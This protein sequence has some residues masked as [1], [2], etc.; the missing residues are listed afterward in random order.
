MSRLNSSLEK[1]LIGHWTMSAKDISAGAISD[2][3]P[4]NN[5]GTINGATQTSGLF[6][7]G[8]NFSSA[9]DHVNIPSQN[10]PSGSEPRTFAIW[11]NVEQIGDRQMV[12]GTGSGQ[13]TGNAFEIEVDSPY[14]SSVKDTSPN[15]IGVHTWGSSAYAS[16]KPLNYNSWEHI[17]ATL[18]GSNNFGIQIY[19]NGE[20][21]PMGVYQ[22]STLSTETEHLSIGSSLAHGANDINTLTGSVQDARIYNRVL[23]DKEISTLYNMRS[24]PQRNVKTNVIYNN[25]QQLY[26]S[27]GHPETTSALDEFFNQS[28]PNV[29]NI[30]STKHKRAS[31]N[32]G[33]NEQE[34]SEFGTVNP[35]PKYFTQKD[36]Y[37]WKIE[38]K[39]T[40]PETG[41]YTFGI[42]GDDAM[43]VLING[44]PVTTFYG[45]H[46]F[47][48]TV[49]NNTGVT[50]LN[51]GERYTI[52]FRYEEGGGGNGATFSYKKPSDSKYVL[53]PVQQ[54]F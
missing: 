26:N 33:G 54:V 45:G 21:Q 49:N 29:T 31:V 11:V 25:T 36:G 6:D 39:W 15:G 19:H 9:S 30:I 43:D 28:N 16:S 20:P 35:L 3:T 17:A 34:T 52:T 5:P 8:L 1:G 44:N 42:D 37:S 46:G 18:D 50:S 24:Q 22:N 4:Y 53:F 12:L 47:D 7:G 41:I 2:S 40:A 38:G 23:S 27:Q 14:N 32:H 10:V 13:G 51:K 48:G